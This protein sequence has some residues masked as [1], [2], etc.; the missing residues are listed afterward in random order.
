MNSERT[1]RTNPAGTETM[2]GYIEHRKVFTDCGVY[3]AP[4]K[5]LREGE[6]RIALGRRYNDHRFPYPERRDGR[7][8]FA[9]PGGGE[10]VV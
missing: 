8:V 3:L 4:V 7:L 5:L 2:E 9:L 10:M 1:P 6:G